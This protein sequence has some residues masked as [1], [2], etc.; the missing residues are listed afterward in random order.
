MGIRKKSK[1][2][3]TDFLFI[4]TPLCPVCIGATDQWQGGGELAHQSN[5]PLNP[6]DGRREAQDRKRIAISSADGM[7]RSVRAI[8]YLSVPDAGKFRQFFCTCH[9]FSKDSPV[10]KHVPHHTME[11]S[12]FVMA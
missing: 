11:E 2:S 12:L 8:L 7:A 9:L 10:I 4:G 6:L 1:S 3:P 5:R